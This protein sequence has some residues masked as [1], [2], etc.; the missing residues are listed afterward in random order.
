MSVSGSRLPQRGSHREGGP[1]T[2]VTD[3]PRCTH[4]TIHPMR[5]PNPDPPQ[6]IRKG[7]GEV[8]TIRGFGGGVV[9]TFIDADQHDRWD[10]RDFEVIRICVECNWEWGQR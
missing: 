1:F 4:V 6:V 2:A 9:L 10:E 8:T 5:V 7:T 3:C